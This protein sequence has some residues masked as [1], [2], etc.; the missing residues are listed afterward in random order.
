MVKGT[1]RQES[2]GYQGGAGRSWIG[3]AVAVGPAAREGKNIY[4]KIYF[5]QECV[6]I[7][8]V[9]WLE[10]LEQSPLDR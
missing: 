7:Q 5:S 4:K 6:G 8:A 1:R 10:P 9:M 2:L 3:A